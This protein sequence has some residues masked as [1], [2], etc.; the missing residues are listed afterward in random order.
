MYS[1]RV[2]ENVADNYSLYKLF[3]HYPRP[4]PTLLII[5]TGCRALGAYIE[6]S[7]NHFLLGSGIV[8]QQTFIMELYTLRVRF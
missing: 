2:K 6:S 1:K 5:F 8:Q 4:P 7:P 3:A